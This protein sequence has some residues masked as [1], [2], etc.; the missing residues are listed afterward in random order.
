MASCKSNHNLLPSSQSFL[1]GI[2]GTSTLILRGSDVEAVA[3]GELD[4]TGVVVL[5]LAIHHPIAV[6]HDMVD[7]SIE[8]V[9]TCQLDIETALEEVFADTKR[10][11]RI[12]TVNPD[13]RARIALGV[14]HDDIAAHGWL[15]QVYGLGQTLCLLAEV[16]LGE[17]GRLQIEQVEALDALLHLPI[18]HQ[19]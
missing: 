3:Q 10:E 16:P 19:V 8:E 9:V 18:A 14:S 11:H 17:N 13:I 2:T 12:S 1:L 4:A 5:H 7:A 6:E 15:Q